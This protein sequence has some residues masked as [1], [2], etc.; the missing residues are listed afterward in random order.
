MVLTPKQRIELKR[1]IASQ[2]WNRERW[3]AE[4]IEIVLGEFDL[5]SPFTEGYNDDLSANVVLRDASDEDLVQLYEYLTDVK[6]PDL[7]A[8]TVSDPP[9]LSPDPPSGF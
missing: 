1:E 4:D 8:E 2:L 7:S 3:S 5:P 9:P 6:R